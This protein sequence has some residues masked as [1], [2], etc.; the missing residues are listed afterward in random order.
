LGTVET[1]GYG[2]VKLVAL[3]ILVRSAGPSAPIEILRTQE[4]AK[5]RTVRI[6]NHVPHF[7]PAKQALLVVKA[8]KFLFLILRSE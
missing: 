3:L 6:L 1:T 5:I 2:T 4:A 7:R 8:E